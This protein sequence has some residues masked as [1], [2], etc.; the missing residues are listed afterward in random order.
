MTAL[1]TS[2]T[3]G[4]AF[5]NTQELRCFHTSQATKMIRKLRPFLISF[6]TVE[7]DIHHHFEN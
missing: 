3:L 7:I 1:R 4:V 2:W 6:G 5:S